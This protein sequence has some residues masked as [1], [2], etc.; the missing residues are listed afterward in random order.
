ML[1]IYF[2]TCLVELLEQR[3]TSQTPGLDAIVVLI[4]SEEDL[5]AET[6]VK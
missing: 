2:L 6:E 4:F 5:E 3:K 1:Y